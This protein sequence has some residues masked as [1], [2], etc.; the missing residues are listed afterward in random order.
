MK[1]I[2]NIKHE[3]FF[4]FYYSYY[5]SIHPILYNLIIN[6]SG[7]KEINQFFSKNYL[8]TNNKITLIFLFNK[9]LIDIDKLKQYIKRY[10]LD[11]LELFKNI[12]LTNFA[13]K[14]ESRMNLDDNQNANYLNLEYK[15]NDDFYKEENKFYNEIFFLKEKEIQEKLDQLK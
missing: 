10:Y 6:N 2:S 11:A 14:S 15:F 3:N 5:F 9:Q 8:N 13:E 12:I 1:K 4:N 7:P